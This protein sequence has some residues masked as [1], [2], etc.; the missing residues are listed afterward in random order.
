MEIIISEPRKD[1][2]RVQSRFPAS[3]GATMDANR[4]PTNLL[5]A[6]LTCRNH[7]LVM[8]SV[9]TE[10][11]SPAWFTWKSEPLGHKL[12]HNTPTVDSL[13]TS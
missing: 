9:I 8:A 5:I 3:T 1:M 13:N 11:D 10:W 6:E 12:R 7:S 4:K 2:L